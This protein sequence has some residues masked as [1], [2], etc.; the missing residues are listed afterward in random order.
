MFF[1]AGYTAGQYFN[2]TSGSQRYGGPADILCLPNNPELTNK[3]I[4]DYSMIYGAE[5]E[6]SGFQSGA[7]N[8]DIPCTVCRNPRASES[9]MIPGRKS[10]YAGWNIEYNG[11][12]ASGYSNDKAS[13]YICMDMHPEYIPGGQRDEDGHR[14]WLIKSKCGSLP[15]PPYHNDYAL[16]CV[17]CS[18]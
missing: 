4:P 17:V 7:I 10:C 18:K 2:P 1:I 13:S 6:G 12:I 16:Y 3:T 5:F 15:C 8:E 11:L 14:I 9:I